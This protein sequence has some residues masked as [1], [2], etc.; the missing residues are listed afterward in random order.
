MDRRGF[1]GKVWL[2]TAA[3]IATPIA[4]RMIDWDAIPSPP[5]VPRLSILSAA[6]FQWKQFGGFISVSG[7]QGDYAG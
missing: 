1:L 5:P 6:E 4:A 3:L 7:V 2:G